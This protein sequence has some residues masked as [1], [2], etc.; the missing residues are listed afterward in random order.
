MGERGAGMG[1]DNKKGFRLPFGA[2]RR[3]KAD[4]AD[5]PTPG[6]SEGAGAKA[7]G[8]RG[9]AE[10]SRPV[11]RTR[12]K[13]TATS[14][15]ELGEK[16]IA[17]VPARIMRPRLVFV[18][19]LVA[20]CAFGLLMV[21]SASS[22]E[23]LK[24]QGSSWYFLFRQAI[25]MAIGFVA[26]A[27]I[28]TR[29]VIPW[30]AF[31]SSASKVLWAFV[32]VLLLVVLAVGAG[33]DT[34]GASRWIPLGFF[35]LQ[36]AELAKPAVIVLAAKILS[37]YYEDGVTDTFSFLVSMAICLG[38]PA[39]LIFAEPDLGTTI[40]IAVTVFAMAYICGISYRL[41]GA[42]FAVFV[43]AAVGL[44]ITS[45]YRFTRLLVF[46]DPWSDPFGDG[47]QATLAIMAF[48]SGG[49]FGRGIGNSTM[50]YNYLPEAHNDYILAII[51]EELGFVG[52][53]IFVLVFLSMIAAGFYIARRSAS[54]HGQ[55]I[56]SGCSFVL[57][58]QFIIN[59][60]GI[61]GLLPM[62]GKPLPFISYGGSSVLTS[63]ILAGLIF[64]VSVESNVQT[65]ADRRRAGLAVL[66][67][68]S[69]DDE[70]AGRERP[71]I[72]RGS[73]RTARLS[74]REQQDISTHLGRSTAGP[75][76]TRSSRRGQ[77]DAGPLPGEGRASRSTGYRGQGLSVYDGGRSAARSRG[78]AGGYRTPR[79]MCDEGGRGSGYERIDLG[80]SA[81][82][83]LRPRGDRPRVDY[84]DVSPSPRPRRSGETR[85]YDD[86]RSTGRSRYDR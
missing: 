37:D 21:Y 58:I 19:C 12:R 38:V 7:P 34:W 52:T 14:H 67:S 35:N 44:A 18:C 49:P 69:G 75:A 13:A 60:F 74:E 54:L 39:I 33:G 57:L 5:G 66:G 16:L 22:V 42:L 72:R 9:D 27:V 63:L 61:L 73:M 56:A 2:A 81:Q 8:T 40:I 41:I 68:A 43:V 10:P 32:V 64:R 70:V 84:G 28:G 59:T 48:A 51:G 85:R 76:R 1:E 20:I 65:A 82:D 55:L 36:P 53:A 26:F 3:A 11:K 4:G 50:K 83:R 86:G 6:R 77:G 80:G 30:R 47:Y 24:E 17:G 23:A 78:A 62:T 45:S 31:R 15:S 71:S 79:G 46:L 25:F 29:A